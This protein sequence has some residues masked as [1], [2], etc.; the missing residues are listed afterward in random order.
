MTA[1]E[2]YV[3]GWVYGYLLQTAGGAGKEIGGDIALAPARPYSANARILTDAQREGLLSAAAGQAV[4]EALWE[5]QQ[6]DP[7]MDGGSEA[8]QPLALQGSWWLGYYAGL[9]GKPLAPA[10]FDI[11]AA[12]KARGMTQ[13]QLAEAMGVDQAHISRWES[14]RVR[15]SAENMNRLRELL[16]GDPHAGR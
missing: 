12:R 1:R 15:P 8:Y 11:A 16:G 10:E 2:A 3:F 5:I 14:G 7:P 13:A 4:G 6:V 9:G